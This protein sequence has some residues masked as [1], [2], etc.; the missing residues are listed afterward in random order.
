MSGQIVQHRYE[1]LRTGTVRVY[2]CDADRRREYA[3]ALTPAEEL[4]LP[5]PVVLQRLADSF[6]HECRIIAGKE[7]DK[8]ATGRV[9]RAASGHSAEGLIGRGDPHGAV[10]HQHA[11]GHLAQCVCR[12]PRLLG[13][14]LAFGHVQVHHDGTCERAVIDRARVEA[15]PATC[16]AR[17]AGIV[18][19][20]PTAGSL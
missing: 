13:G 5:K 3:A 6:E 14:E 10:S 17:M 8:I 7:L 2:C 12:E 16:R 1:M 4:A 9:I 11:L 15:E 19:G 18:D 20:E